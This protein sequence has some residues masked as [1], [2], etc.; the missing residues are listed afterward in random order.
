[1]TLLLGLKINDND[2]SPISDD[3]DD[4]DKPSTTSAATIAARNNK[5]ASVATTDFRALDQE[6]DH[7]LTLLSNL[8]ISDN[9]DSLISDDDGNSPLTP[10]ALTTVASNNSD[11]T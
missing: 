5:H 8:K 4:D 3:D 2:D 7:I 11:V 1:M 9:D 10:S 6:L